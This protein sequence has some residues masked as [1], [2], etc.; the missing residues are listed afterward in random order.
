M[1]IRTLAPLALL[2]LATAARADVKLPNILAEHMLV[3]RNL[4]VHLWGW[5][6]PGENV[7]ASFRGHSANIIADKLGMWSL[8]LPPGDAGGPFAM[9]ISGHNQISFHDILVGDVWVASG[10]SNMEMPIG[11][12]GPW[13]I[14]VDNYKQVLA[15]ANIPTLRLYHLE[16]NT[17]HFPLHDAPAATW[18]PATA[19]SVNSFSAVGYYFARE[20]LQHEHI[21]IA[22]I[23]ADVGATPAEAWT[24]MDA[25]TADGSNRGVFQAWTENA[26]AEPTRQLRSEQAI[27]AAKSKG[28]VAVVTAEQKRGTIFQGP[29]ELWNAMIYPVV[30]YPV[31]GFLWY[32][33]DN[34]ASPPERVRA[35]QHLFETMITDWRMQWGEGD[36]PFLFVQLNG[37]PGNIDL[38][39]IREAQ[40]RTLE[41]PNTGMAVS[42]DVGDPLVYHATNK[43]PVSYRLALWARANTYGEHL[44]Y[45]GPLFL[46]ATIDGDAITAHFTHADGMTAKGGILKGFEVAGADGVFHTAT[47]TIRGSNVVAQSAAVTAPRFVRYAWANNPDCPL[48]NAAGLPAATFTSQP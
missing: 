15:E 43:F 36:L 20:I 24:S 48:F 1:R 22:V 10:Q 29:A 39:G 14:G 42:I 33:G 34:N 37:R 17:S 19:E 23:E 21:P 3:Q 12:N 27:R 8:T 38:P 28:D 9:T 41:L 47:A 13:K 32:Q 18:A 26:D 5:A 11:L 35:Y 30:P 6:D 7:Q 45:S 40:L 46:S 16:M 44:E 2:L 4:P 31:R 25:L